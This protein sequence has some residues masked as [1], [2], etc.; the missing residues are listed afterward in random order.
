VKRVVSIA[1]TR[2]L[3]RTMASRVYVIIFAGL[4][5]AQALSFALMFYERDQ[6]ATTVM[7]D[8]VEHEVG[9]SVAVLDRLPA[10]ERAHWLGRLQRDNYRFVLGYGQPGT[11]LAT[12]RSRE[13]MQRI[14]REVGPGFSVRGDTISMHPERYQVH[15]TLHDGTPL[16]LE[17]TP[18]GVPPIA[19]WLPIML[20]VQLLVL[21]LC[22]W[23]AV[24]LTTRP[25][26]E[27]ARAA[28]AMTPTADGPRLNEAGP[29]EVA[30]AAIAFNTMQE[31]IGRHLKERLHILAAVSHDLQTPITRMRLRAEVLE[32]GE[33]RRKMLSDLHE[34][35]HL[36]R[37]GVAYARS[38]HGGAETPVRIDVGAFLESLVFDYQDMGQPVTLPEGI[39]GTAT[40]R[41]Q[42]LRRVLGNLIDNAVKYAGAAEV[43]AWHDEAGRLCMAVRDR[44]IGIPE[45]QLQRVLEPFYRLEASRNRDT[46]GAGLGLAIAA[47]L[48]RAIGGSLHLSNREG[49]G[50]TATIALP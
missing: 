49:G 27:L 20:V 48:T 47:Q 15:F 41:A 44:G 23:L 16:T 2:W 10:A 14:E 46:G 30:Q 4:M 31:R 24:R 42:A 12:E 37:E 25:L 18:R 26:R 5:L 7:L 28:E 17:V 9:T 50:L 32:E 13:V 11:A 36:V 43:T 34:M 6:S 21:L 8:S 39:R 33:E 3:P 1:S 22:T 29:V 40:V 45:D 38:V 19:R 35:E